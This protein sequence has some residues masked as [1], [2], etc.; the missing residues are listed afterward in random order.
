MY[1]TAIEDRD[2]HGDRTTD[3]VAALPWRDG[4]HGPACPRPRPGGRGDAAVTPARERGAV[5][6]DRLVGCVH[7]V[8][9]R[10][11]ARQLG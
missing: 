4:G 8:C 1:C 6:I 11:S 5:A 9:I 7:L 10:G 2:M 3:G